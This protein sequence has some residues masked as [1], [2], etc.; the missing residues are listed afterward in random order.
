MPPTNLRQTFVAVSLA[1]GSLGM[2]APPQST[3][4][5]RDQIVF[6]DADGKRQPIARF[7]GARWT[8]T[9]SAANDASAA[10]VQ[11]V[12]RVAARSAEWNAIE[13]TVR[14][15]FSRREREQRLAVARLASVAM[16][17]ENV[18]AVG[19]AANATYYFEAAKQIEDTNP[20]ADP[21]TDPAGVVVL[22]VTGWLRA[23]GGRST[24]IGSKADVEW[25]Q[26]DRV[27]ASSRVDLVPVGAIGQPDSLVWIM[28]RDTGAAATFL[29]YETRAGSVRALL[30]SKC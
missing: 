2:A 19:P 9:C 22:R 11:P 20:N 24:P 26:L 17:L 3:S 15:I 4:A 10:P 13:P 6:V 29:F 1:C 16:T 8:A 30:E 12:R 7:D 5:A 14:E 21:D 18:S 25:R 23:T 27:D 28:K